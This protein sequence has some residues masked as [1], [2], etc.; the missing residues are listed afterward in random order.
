MPFDG[1]P[2]FTGTVRVVLHGR[3]RKFGPVHDIGI[4]TAAEAFRALSITKPG[5]REA[6]AEGE[7]RVVRGKR[8]GGVDLDP[9]G[10]HLRVAPGSE[11]HVVP[12]GKG[13]GGRGGGAAKAILGATIMVAAVVA[14]GGT[15][16]GLAA[17]IVSGWAGTIT[18]GNVFMF[19]AAMFLGGVSQLVSPQPKTPTRTNVSDDR[20]YLLSGVSNTVEQG[21]PVPL[22]Y[23]RVRVGSIV[24]SIG[25]SAE[26]YNP[27]PATSTGSS[28]PPVVESAAPPGYYEESTVEWLPIEGAGGG[29]GGGGAKGG[30]G[31]GHVAREAPN[32]LR[33]R[34]VVR[35]IDVL[36]EGPIAGLVDGA[37]S[38]YF[39]N[40]P[41][42]AADGTWN[43]KGVT[44]E[45]RTGE[46]DQDPVSGYPAAEQSSVVN[47]KVTASSP[48]TQTVTSA[49]ATAVRVTIRIPALYE[50]AT[51]G[52]LNPAPN[53]AYTVMVRPVAGAWTTVAD[54]LITNGKCT[55]PYE[56]S[57]RFDLPYSATNSW[58]VRVTRVTADAGSVTIANETWWAALDLITDHRLIYPNT[59]YIAL[60]ID[61][62]AFGSMLPT[63]SYDIKGLLVQVPLNYDPVARTYATTG[64]G[65]TAGT[66]NGTSWK[67]AWT[68]NPAWA[69]W[70][71]ITSTRYGAGLSSSALSATK[72]DLYDIAQ[73]CDASVPTG[74]AGGGTEA[75]YT[76]NASV[77]D[78]EDAYRLLQKFVSNFRGMFYW[79]GGSL[80]FSA[81]KPAS[82][83]KLL[84][85]ASVLDG[86][87]DYES[88]SL[89]SRHNAARV[90]WRDPGDSWAG[91]VEV[92]EDYTRTTLPGRRVAD[93]VAF[94][95]TSR[96]QSHRMGKWLIDAENGQPETV[97][98]GV[99]I[100]NMDMRPGDVVAV[101]D[102]S[103]A[104][105]RMGGRVRGGNTTTRIYLDSEVTFTAG[106]WTISVVL[107]DGTVAQDRTITTT[108]TA[109]GASYVNLSAALSAVPQ[110]GTP[111][112]LK[113]AAVAP[114]QFRVV[115]MV[116][117]AR[118]EFGVVALAHDPTKFDRIEQN[119]ILPEPSYSVLQD[120][121]TGP[122]PRLGERTYSATT[123]GGSTTVTL[124]DV[125]GL[126]VGMLV[127]GDE[128]YP[129]GTYISAIN[130]GTNVVT[131]SAARTGSGAYTGAMKFIV[132]SAVSYLV[133]IGKTTV[134]RTT[135]SW[136]QPTDIRVDHVDI[137]A[138]TSER[139]VGFFTS[140][141]ASVDID[142]LEPGYYVFAVRAVGRD[143]RS[144]DWVSG[145]AFLV[146]GQSVA[147]PV[148]TGLVA[149]GGT[150]RVQ[151]TWDAS[152]ARDLKHYQIWRKV[153]GTT[154]GADP[155]V[156]G[157]A[158]F[159]RYSGSSSATDND[160]TSLQ[161]N[162]TAYYWV[163]AI[164]TTDIPGPWAGPVGA[165]TTLL[166]VDDIADGI[167]NAAKMASSIKPVEIIADLS[168][169]KPDG[170]YAVNQVDGKLYRRI[171][172]VW[173]SLSDA[174]EITGQI[175]GSQIADLAISADK[176][177][178]YAVTAS[179]LFA[180]AVGPD[181]I[182]ANAIVA[183]KL[184][185][186]EQANAYPDFDM[187]DT[188]F[189]SGD[190]F[191][192]TGTNQAVLGQNRLFIAASSGAKV[193]RS[194]WF[195]VEVSA[196]YSVVG[197]AYLASSG[198]TTAQ[199][200]IEF[201]SLDSS[202]VVTSTRLVTVQAATS[203]TSPTRAVALVTTSSS[204]RR[205]RYVMTKSA[206]P[207]AGANFGGFM[208]RRRASGE[209]I[210]DGA[211]TAAKVA[212]GA[213]ETNALAAGSI[214]A[215]KI[216]A[217]AIVASKLSITGGTVLPDGG[218][219]DTAA[220][221]A[222]DSASYTV[223]DNNGSNV[224]F[225]LG[226][227]RAAVLASPG[228]TGTAQKGI[229]SV[230]FGSVAA[231]QVYRL[232]ARGSNTNTTRAL[233][234]QLYA[235]DSAGALVGSAVQVSWLNETASGKEVQF[236]VPTNGIRLVVGVVVPS[237]AAW[238][239]TAAVGEVSVVQAVTGTMV[240][241]GSITAAK[242]AALTITANELAA[243]SVIAGKISAGAVGASEI[244]ANV[245][246]ASHLA[247]STLITLSAQI[248][249][250][251]I[252]TAQIATA[253]ITS[254][255]IGNLQ[256]TSAQIDNLTV[257]TGKIA[258]NAA[259]RMGE[260]G[261]FSNITYPG[262]RS[263]GSGQTACYFST[264]LQVETNGTVLI[265]VKASLRP[266]DT[267]GSGLGGAN[268]GEG[269]S[270]E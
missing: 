82:P 179:K 55:S 108:G 268:P 133:G 228:F 265:F 162:T 13:S 159:L 83:V 214:V 76:L 180:G 98:F 46:P 260:T 22:V 40:T 196:D 160:S 33:S 54:E 104:G 25:Y 193:V 222:I 53:L 47:L 197:A 164:S 106:T 148:V 270:G 176:L 215:A 125:S 28:S 23:G 131:L 195:N 97:N 3:L 121:V 242:I 233:N 93:I 257:G 34:A 116:E 48:V 35:I 110:P 16:A 243:D 200:E 135:V 187:R 67:L 26:E 95:S 198:A 152:A 21:S 144:G 60:T 167:V 170:S 220:F 251:V 88:T 12:V 94:G 204:E 112:I 10:L 50:Q 29:G 199:L 99:S 101:A 189:Y 39:N 202:G 77:V 1:H 64:P 90:A 161:P 269:A 18:F 96:G 141:G 163:R 155:T 11:L 105:L 205:A 44:W 156:V 27:A 84:N 62:E 24:A 166:I 175:D 111:F 71:L 154:P 246:T 245:I 68:D 117:R 113:S 240:V 168:V 56:R 213:I 236:T 20:S 238:S 244:A 173:T 194:G 130:T 191:L 118:G 43:F 192:I 58:D 87:F 119:I 255:K 157:G 235:V 36:G 103:Y 237:G 206:D 266:T 190:T 59:A 6:M 229:S 221:W 253:A 69:L 70:D 150:R 178:D 183:S 186:G 212:A 225:T 234:V 137:R 4:L 72:W 134:T 129:A 107:P 5:F 74:F 86:R 201:G 85:Q 41:L 211:I 226:V 32:N 100:E 42:Q 261:Q 136:Y 78:Q 254:A 79:A 7:Y 63:R 15:A 218:F 210:V 19:G 2:S 9:L 146:S 80:C 17:P 14:S 45:V 147:P 149:I 248:G 124:T 73:Y 109:A 230:P 151:L 208:V 75:R 207:A 65:T 102:D 264:S 232:R 49:T 239:G 209:L 249:T 132:I 262:G 153:G 216:A 122:M 224:A 142:N 126:E 241:D 31:G 184:W 267:A 89:A 123:S 145:G 174:S 217:G 57:H 177:D 227:P 52:D 188:A 203:A 139:I 171:G 231:G 219:V 92:V 91:A 138:L 181:A 66:W 259:T 258:Y 263:P 252:D 115:G 120:L 127:Q 158:A 143:G 128:P 114:R 51:S 223:E 140:A 61:S 169:T 37:K 250:G 38:I 247:T 182:A 165:T 81:D 185:L 30:G 8:R 172:A 256:V